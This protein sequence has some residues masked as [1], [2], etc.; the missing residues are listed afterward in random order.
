MKHAITL[1][2]LACALNQAAAASQEAVEASRWH[3]VIDAT[4]GRAQFLY[5][6]RPEPLFEPRNEAE[7]A[8]LAGEFIAATRARHGVVPHTLVLDDVRFLPLGQI[9]AS[10]KWAVRYRQELDGIPVVGGALCVLLDR[11]GQP[12]SLQTIALPDADHLRESPSLSAGA[13]RSRALAVFHERHGVHADH[14]GEPRL[15]VDQLDVPGGRV[16]VLAW[17]LE[18]LYTAAGERPVGERLRVSARTGAF[19]SAESTVHD[20]DVTGTVSTY[21]TP[22]SAPDL[23]S[24]GPVLTPV[25]DVYVTCDQGARQTDG[26]GDFTFQG[27]DTITNVVIRYEGAWARVESDWYLD[28]K[29]E[30]DSFST[31]DPAPIMNAPNGM[32]PGEQSFTTAEANAYVTLNRMRSWLL[33]VDPGDDIWDFQAFALVNRGGNCQAGMFSVNG[34][35]LSFE[36]ASG[37]DCLHGG[38]SSWIAHEM[39]H[40]LSLFYG[41]G[42]GFGLGEGTADV[43]AMYLLDTPDVGLDYYEEG[44]G[45]VRSG[46]NDKQFCGFEDGQLVKDCLGVDSHRNGLP[47]MG[48]AWKVRRNLKLTHGNGAGSMVADELFLS[49]MKSYNQFQ[50]HPVIEKQWLLL[51]DDDGNICTPSPNWDDIRDGFAEHGLTATL[52]PACGELNGWIGID[53]GDD[54]IGPYLTTI[55]VD[56]PIGGVAFASVHYRVSGGV[57]QTVPLTPA[58]PTGGNTYAAEVPGQASPAFIEYYYAVADATGATMFFPEEAP[59]ELL[60]AEVGTRVEIRRDDFELQAGWTVENDMSLVSGAWERV[61]PVGSNAAPEDAY[62]GTHCYVT[63]QNTVGGGDEDDDVDGGPTRLVSPEIDLVGLWPHVSFQRWTMNPQTTSGDCLIWEVTTDGGASWTP[64]DDWAGSDDGVWR[65][66]EYFLTGLTDATG[67]PATKVR[68]RFSATEGGDPSLLEAAIDDFRV[69]LLAPSGGCIPTSNYCD[70]TPNSVGP[71]ASMSSSGSVS[72]GAN[73]LV[74]SAGPCPPGQPG[75]FFYGS[76]QIETPFGNG[77]RCAGGNVFR[78]NPPILVDPTGAATRPLDLT[79]A[80]ANLGPGQIDPWSSWNF[81]FWYRDP[82]AGGAGFNL[83]DALHVVFCP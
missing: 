29:L 60:L 66:E 62:E 15:V 24:N 79:A 35:K 49:W 4:T 21:A 77:N 9:G 8:F 5:G 71:G 38:Y 26:N 11:T 67:A 59:A 43:F 46:M 74:L 54:E 37:D 76:T 68:F 34:P 16:P 70:L 12:L 73:E 6:A 22:G 18:L 58:S 33:E 2:L 55:D 57:W 31:G 51:D 44:Y 41:N 1:A 10:D 53:P 17:E 25:P 47:F 39:G 19:T 72:A 61:D 14:V 27:V 50:L 64:L 63:G 75:V 78:L 82:A 28:Y 81:Q 80:P 13:A 52:P 20:F 7:C 40:W 69:S 48:A 32:P 23:D 30:L 56:P 36:R 83:S 3:A 65:A 42:G 45:P